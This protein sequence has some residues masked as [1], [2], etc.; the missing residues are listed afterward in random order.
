MLWLLQSQRL[1]GRVY[2]AGAAPAIAGIMQFV[3]AGPGER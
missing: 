3:M 1:S 2:P